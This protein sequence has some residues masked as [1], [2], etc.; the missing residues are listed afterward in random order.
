M[1][2]LYSR[3]IPIEAQYL[4]RKAH[5]MAEQGNDTSALKYYRQALII[6]P[7]YTKAMYEMGD[8]YAHM[9]M[10]EKAMAMY[11]RAVHTDPGEKD[12]ADERKHSL[13]RLKNGEGKGL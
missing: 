1:E 11:D 13:L 9:G 7:S 12:A 6:A 4:Y 3:G 8:S 10:F 2:W 5:E